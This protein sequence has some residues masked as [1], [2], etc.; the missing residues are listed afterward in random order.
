MIPDRRHIACVD[1]GCPT[2]VPM[3]EKLQPVKI[4]KQLSIL[5]NE[6][7]VVKVT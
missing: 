1:I 5:G 4:F 7:Q 3:K 6:Q 2:P